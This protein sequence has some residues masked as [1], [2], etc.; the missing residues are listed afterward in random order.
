MDA[1]ADDLA[2]SSPTADALVRLGRE[3]DPEAWELLVRAH[4]P[5]LRR[6]C[7][8]VLR[9]DA[10][11]DDACQEALLAIR[12]AA[13]RFRPAADG[14]EAQAVGWL[15]RV[16]LTAALR[17]ERD[18]SRR[19]RRERTLPQSEEI[20][21]SEAPSM[22]DGA[23]DPVQARAVASALATLPD[24][25]RRALILHFDA[26]LSYPQLARALGC[27]VNAARVRIHRAL[28]ALRRTVAR[29]GTPMGA[30]VLAACLATP[31]AGAG[32]AGSSTSQL[33]RLIDAPSS[34]GAS[35][36]A[37]LAAASLG[38]GALI[39]ASLAF[40]ILG[41]P[42]ASDTAVVVAARSP[43]LDAEQLGDL[44]VHL[45]F[46]DAPLQEVVDHF[47]RVLHIPLRLDPAIAAAEPPP[48]SLT[49]SA[50]RVRYALGLFGKLTGTTFTRD[51]EGL[52][53]TNRADAAPAWGEPQPRL[54]VRWPEPW[55]PC[56][57]EERHASPARLLRRMLAAGGAV[58]TES[59]RPVWDDGRVDVRLHLPEGDVLVRDDSLIV[60]LAGAHPYD[61][62]PQQIALLA[63]MA[64]RFADAPV[65]AVLDAVAAATGV[66]CRLDDR[67]GP[68]PR[69]TLAIDR[70]AAGTLLR[71]VAQRCD[72]ALTEAADGMAIFRPSSS[73]FRDAEH[74]HDAS[75]PEWWSFTDRFAGRTV[76]LEAPPE[77]RRVS[78]TWQDAPL[79][80]VADDLARLT[81]LPVRLRADAA[82][83]QEP[84][85]LVLGERD[86]GDLLA[87][88]PHVTR[89][90]LRI[91]ADG[92]T[93]TRPRPIDADPV[94][95]N[96]P[97][98]RPDAG[99]PAFRVH[100]G[101]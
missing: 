27:S 17:V 95:P 68:F 5:A 50:T 1:P 44:E 100:A 20:A 101:G 88:V 15:M 32:A 74:R 8:R 48:V 28:E 94:D 78:V 13:A 92:L 14:I 51:G 6:L 98:S 16:G 80:A 79:A 59:A 77:S 38:A 90:H 34:A 71:L 89:C 61:A 70:I 56:S 10:A 53:V 82:A 39:A 60:A 87:I 93:L 52:L 26:G 42:A 58:V 36:S 24:R 40:A 81:G 45:E 35:G 2:P 47:D 83:A 84:V 86:L 7:W 65:E 97:P 43:A 18:R 31:A 99:K 23:P 29:A 69:L 72:A 54:A 3:R 62:T 19:R 76:A 85:L 30:S 73:R 22:P 67:S 75:R 55:T 9:D 91:D 57:L 46:Q 66:R 49:V 4:A 25:H 96:P 63:P 64:A 12:D 21:A 37:I 33:V 41:P 11:A